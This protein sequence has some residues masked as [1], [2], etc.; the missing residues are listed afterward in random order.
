MIAIAARIIKFQISDDMKSRIDQ[1]QQGCKSLMEKFDRRVGID[2][3][4][5]VK[6]LARNSMYSAHNWCLHFVDYLQVIKE[7]G[8]STYMSEL[9]QRSICS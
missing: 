3:N 2:T 1:C 8:L 7:D 5:R 4:E 9:S 6:E